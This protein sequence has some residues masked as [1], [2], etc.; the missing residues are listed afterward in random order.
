MNTLDAIAYNILNKMRGGRSSNNDLFS[1]DQIKYNIEVYRSLFLRRDMQ[2]SRDLREFE[3]TLKESDSE[4][5]SMERVDLSNGEDFLGIN[6]ALKSIKKIPRPVRL[7]NQF[8]LNIT[9]PGRKTIYPVIPYQ[10][11]HLQQFNRYTKNNPRA[12]LLDGHLYLIG[13]PASQEMLNMI[14]NNPT[15]NFDWSKEISKVQVY[16]VF[17]EPRK[18]MEFNGIDPDETSSVEYPISYDMIQQITESM[19]KIEMNV[20][21]QTPNETAINPN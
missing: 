18:A 15:E 21:S 9:Q 1:L 12:F 16:G 2:N 7:K 19:L 6:F 5:I 13:D 10:Y 20:M 3:Q 14:A 17:E 4:F 11:I 8:A